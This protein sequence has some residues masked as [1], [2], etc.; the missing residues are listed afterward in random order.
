[1]LT[2]NL[3]FL[4]NSIGDSGVYFACGGVCLV[5]FLFSLFVVRETKGKSM[6]EITDMFSEKKPPMLKM[7]KPQIKRQVI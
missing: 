4:Q 6:H 3:F 5:G 2:R 7:R 1:M